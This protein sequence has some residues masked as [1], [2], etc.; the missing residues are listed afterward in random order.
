MMKKIKSNKLQLKELFEYIEKYHDL[1]VDWSNSTLLLKKCY[2]NLADLKD[3]I[4]IEFADKDNMYYF[5][6]NKINYLKVLTPYIKTV[7]ADGNCNWEETDF[8]CL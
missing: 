5:I 1:Y 6:R 2:D 7:T 3:G 8:N 4:I